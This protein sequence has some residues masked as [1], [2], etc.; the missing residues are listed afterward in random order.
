MAVSIV[1]EKRTTS[2]PAALLS[3]ETRFV[4]D[5]GKTAIPVIMEEHVMTKKAAVKVI[6]AV[7]VIISD[8]YACLPSLNAQSRFL[9]N[10]AEGAIAIVLVKMRDWRF[11]GGPGCVKPVPI[12]Y[13]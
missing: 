9:R 3:I 8:T 5:V 7:I 13:V 6:P 12:S 1:V 10:I 11:S 4:R 2:S